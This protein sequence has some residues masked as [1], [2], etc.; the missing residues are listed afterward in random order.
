M[1]FRGPGWKQLPG[2]VRERF[3]AAVASGLSPTAAATVAGVHGATGRRWAREAGHRANSKHFGIRYTPPQREVFW[4]AV[5]AGASPEQASVGAGV[6]ETAGRRWL[7]QADYVPRTQLPADH[8][9]ASVIDQTL[10]PRCPLS[11]IERCRLEEL[12]EHGY[13]PARAAELM[14]R[15]KDTINRE[16]ARG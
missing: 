16:I 1:G 8:E 3:W 13:P 7:Q 9:L 12:L 5:K 14:G 11:F 6:S 4:T 2:S 15:H 10:P